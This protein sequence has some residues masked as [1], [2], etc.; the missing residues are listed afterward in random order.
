[1]LYYKKVKCDRRTDKAGCRVACTRLK[2]G[3]GAKTKLIVPSKK[4]SNK[5]YPRGPLGAPFFYTK[6][7]SRI[8]PR[9]EIRDL[10]GFFKKMAQGAKPSE[11]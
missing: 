6:G 11:Q 7:L 4:P 2:I 8:T 3:T 5:N 1:M 10:K 9:R